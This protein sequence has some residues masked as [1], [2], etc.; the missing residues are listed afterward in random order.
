MCVHVCVCLCMCVC[1]CPFVCVCPYACS[2]VSVSVCVSMCV[3]VCVL[4]VCVCLCVCVSC[5]PHH[6]P[7]GVYGSGHMAVVTVCQTRS[8]VS[9]FPLFCDS[10]PCFH[11]DS[12]SPWCFP[13]AIVIAM[14]PNCVLLMFLPWVLFC[15]LCSLHDKYLLSWSSL[16]PDSRASTPSHIPEFQ[17]LKILPFH[18]L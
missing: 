16:E 11:N 10:I 14:C 7:S 17:S 5:G 9:S 13:E 8:S 6:P 4:C 1:V 18:L 2:C 15:L 12:L 3:C